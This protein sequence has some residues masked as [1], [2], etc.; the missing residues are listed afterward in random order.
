ML[1]VDYAAEPRLDAKH[2]RDEIGTAGSGHAIST[3]FAAAA[4]SP[5]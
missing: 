5:S 1:S 2:A 4:H 3:G